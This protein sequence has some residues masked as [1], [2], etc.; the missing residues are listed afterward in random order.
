MGC[1]TDPRRAL[2]MGPGSERSGG[3]GIV[4]IE[5]SADV[6][7]SIGYAMCRSSVRIINSVSARNAGSSAIDELRITVTSEPP[8][9]EAAE[10]V[11]GKVG[12]GKVVDAVIGDAA[13]DEDL[14]ANIDGDLEGLV[15]I[16]A[17]ADG[18]EIPAQIRPVTILPHNMWPGRDAPEL[19]SAF[20]DPESQTVRGMLRD[21]SDKLREAGEEEI[22]YGYGDEDRNRRIIAAIHSAIRDR[23][24]GI[25]DTD[26]GR[27]N[28]GQRMRDA[29][30]MDSDGDATRAEMATL[31]ASVLESAGLYPV[32]I[33]ADEEILAGAWVIENR[34]PDAV[35]YDEQMLREPVEKGELMLFSTDS[36]S[37]TGPFT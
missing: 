35:I 25:E 15:R 28:E 9:M 2:G 19:I 33:F 29:A 5:I 8:F 26:G 4:N 11:F 12:P 37:G 27:H 6:N 3:R 1:C 21:A 14:L 30:E 31:F 7:G 17:Y 32:L 22:S 23:E 34:F 36:L 13:L 24:I 10:Y 20:I 18:I 16:E